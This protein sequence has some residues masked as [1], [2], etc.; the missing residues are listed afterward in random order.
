MILLSLMLFPVL[1]TLAVLLIAFSTEAVAA[2]SRF[3]N[4]RKLRSLQTGKRLRAALLATGGQ[5]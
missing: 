4:S 2:A 3:S 5:S 1:W